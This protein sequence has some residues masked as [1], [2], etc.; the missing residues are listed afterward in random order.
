MA[1]QKIFL[2]NRELN[3][4]EI[5]LRR[6]KLDSLMRSLIVTLSSRCNLG[7]IMCEVRR[8][9]WDI[10]QKT[11]REVM[12]LFP[13]LESVNWQGGEPF[14]LEYFE[15]IFDEAAKFT[16]LKQTIVTNGLLVTERW[17]DKLAA[18]NVELTFSIDGITKEVYEHIRA[19]ARFEDVIRALDTVKKA[20]QKYGGGN[21]TLRLH[22]VVMKSNYHQ[23]EEFMDFAGEYGFNAVHILSLWGNHDSQENIF[24]LADK[25]PL[26]HVL[27]L[28]DKLNERA[29]TRGIVLL[30]SLPL[31]QEKP[32]PVSG[33]RLPEAP[34]I[35][36]DEPDLWCRMPWYQLNIDPGGM[37][38][39]GCTCLKPVGSILDN[40]ITEL[41][42]NELTQEYR[43][44]IPEKRCA[45]LCHPD[46]LV[47]QISEQSR[48]M[49]I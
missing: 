23:L 46:C 10:P 5:R 48:A 21:M 13:Y 6:L 2:S 33:I 12:G 32:S 36:A 15:D 17:A 30:N 9:E 35:A 3:E 37:V 8:S 47:E 42:N 29:R 18:N 22:V 19:R 28:R 24:N 45:H 11:L 4:E 34:V 14:L 20:R 49:R 25:G 44:A 39:P 31:A 26:N 27:G 38:R 41:W 7:C 43:R 16:N 1:D 40:S